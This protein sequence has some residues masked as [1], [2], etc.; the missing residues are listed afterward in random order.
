MLAIQGEFNNIE[1]SPDVLTDFNHMNIFDKCMTLSV[2]VLKVISSQLKDISL[3]SST[4][5]QD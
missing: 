2:T 5:E 3:S 4:S 1:L